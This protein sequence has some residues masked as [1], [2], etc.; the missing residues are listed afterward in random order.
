MLISPYSILLF[1]FWVG[2]WRRLKMNLNSGKSRCR[3]ARIFPAS[4]TSPHARK[5]IQGRP[6]SGTAG[7]LPVGVGVGDGFDSIDSLLGG[8]LEAGDGDSFDAASAA[9][10]AGR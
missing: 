8:D 2:P 10:A 4:L 7:S 9:S 1:S 3:D 6:C 5:S